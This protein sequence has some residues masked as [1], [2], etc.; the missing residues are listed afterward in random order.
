MN[1]KPGHYIH[2]HPSCGQKP[3]IHRLNK[4]K[5]SRPTS[6]ELFSSRD[7]IPQDSEAYQPAKLVRSNL[8]VRII[9][10]LSTST[11]SPPLPCHFLISP[12]PYHSKLQWR[13]D[14]KAE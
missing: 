1:T 10:R 9:P 6:L 4:P 5:I 13:F 2:P 8:Q 11:R 7:K 12:R 3:Q 14:P